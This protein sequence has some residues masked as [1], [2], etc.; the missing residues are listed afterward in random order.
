MNALDC[1]FSRK[2]DFGGGKSTIPT[3]ILLNDKLVK[4]LLMYSAVLTVLTIVFVGL[5]VKQ[6]G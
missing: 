3:V 6:Y 1:Q 5:G 2:K 4:F